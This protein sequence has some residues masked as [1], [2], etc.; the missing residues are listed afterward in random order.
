MGVVQVQGGLTEEGEHPPGQEAYSF[1]GVP[2][3]C[4]KLALRRERVIKQGHH[5]VRE[6]ALHC[7]RGDRAL[8]TVSLVDLQQVRK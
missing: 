3:T 6:V 4:F 8:P 2:L 5:L 7:A 1:G